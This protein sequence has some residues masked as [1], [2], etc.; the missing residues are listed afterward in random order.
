MDT[1]THKKTLIKGGEFIVKHAAPQDIYSPEDINE[2]Q[3]AFSDA[4]SEFVEKRIA[5]QFDAIEHKDFDK[6]VTLLEEAGELGLLGPVSPKPMEGWDW[7]LIAKPTSLKS[8]AVP[9]A[10]A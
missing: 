2:E 7:T 6:V 1:A 8:W 4:T 9:K 3:R 5:P 10:L